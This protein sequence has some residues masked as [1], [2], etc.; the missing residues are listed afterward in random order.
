MYIRMYMHIYISLQDDRIRVL[1]SPPLG[2]GL[3]RLRG[4]LCGATSTGFEGGQLLLTG[5][6][7]ELLGHVGSKGLAWLRFKDGAILDTGISLKAGVL[8]TWLRTPTT[9]MKIVAT[10]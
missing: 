8:F 4:C 5:S 2:G 7:L 10:K 9:T 6:C 3:R 1:H